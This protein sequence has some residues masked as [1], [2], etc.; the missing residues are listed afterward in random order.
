MLKKIFTAMLCFCLIAVGVVG[1]SQEQVEQEKKTEVVTLYLPDDQAEYV[2]PTECEIKIAKEDVA[3]ALISALAEQG[4]LP[5]GIAVKTFSK[6]E[7]VLTLDLNQAFEDAVANSGTAGETMLMA[8]VADTFL[9]YY[10]AQSLT[11]TV[12]GQPIETGHAVYD[13]PFTQ[14]FA[15]APIE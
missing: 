5:E 13:E 8:S 14:I 12:E 9:S 7:N 3:G 6:E 1:C 4:A 10:G 2:E 11:I 15:A